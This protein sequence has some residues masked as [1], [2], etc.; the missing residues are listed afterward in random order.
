MALEGNMR[1]TYVR[2]LLV[3]F[4]VGRAGLPAAAVE[5]PVQELPL[6]VQNAA[7]IWTE[8]IKSV[9]EYS[10]RFDPISGLWLG[11][12]DGTRKSVERTVRIIMPEEGG[13]APEA[14]K[15]FKYNF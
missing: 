1:T 7:T 13:E 14:S 6:D 11:L 9:A 5:K 8:P 2:V 4:G 12:L 3:V 15:Q 10:R